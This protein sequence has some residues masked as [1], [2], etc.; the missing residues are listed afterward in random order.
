M[1]IIWNQSDD[2]YWNNDNGWGDYDSAT[3]FSEAEH[4]Y[5]QL[6]IGGSWLKLK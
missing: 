4:L 3:V 6:P 1:Y 2:T 5:L